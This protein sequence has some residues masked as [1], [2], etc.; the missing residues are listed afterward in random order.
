M[1]LPGS[2][3]TKKEFQMSTLNVE[4]FQANVT[5]RAVELI[6]VTKAGRKDRY[7]RDARLFV[8]SELKQVSDVLAME[9]LRTANVSLADLG[10][11]LPEAYDTKIRSANDGQTLAEASRSAFLVALS[12]RG[13]EAAKPV[14]QEHTGN[15][16]L[17]DIVNVLQKGFSRVGKR[18]HA[19]DVYGRI[20]LYAVMFIENP[21]LANFGSLISEASYLDGALQ[22]EHSA[23][24]EKNPHRKS[25]F[26]E[27]SRAVFE[28]HSIGSE[29]ARDPAR[30]ASMVEVFK[31]DVEDDKVDVYINDGVNRFR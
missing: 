30:F 31:V 13:L 4:A 24:Y 18:R 11:I 10:E 2:S 15:V 1:R 22:Q 29:I 8:V 6:A 7:C 23:L 14:M 12:D 25:T 19:G 17:T 27:I 21:T 20:N 28:M 3:N 16:T 5:S 9:A 26:Q